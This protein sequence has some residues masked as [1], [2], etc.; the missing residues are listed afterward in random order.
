MKKELM[1][2]VLF[3]CD[4]INNE[5]N[6]LDV[7]ETSCHVK[8]VRCPENEFQVEIDQKNHSETYGKLM[9]LYRNYI[10]SER[11]KS[12]SLRYVAQRLTM[13]KEQV[14]F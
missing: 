3:Q 10:E 2:Q 7:V 11:I 4:L 5:I 9:R 14:L 8:T 12:R 1:C 6:R 13:I